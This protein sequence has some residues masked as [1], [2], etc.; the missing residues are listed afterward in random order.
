MALEMEAEGLEVEGRVEDGKAAAMAVV[1]TAAEP[2]VEVVGRED[3]MAA[4]IAVA[5]VEGE[6]EVAAAKGLG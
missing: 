3:L 4:E 6:R 2:L 5:M 1:S